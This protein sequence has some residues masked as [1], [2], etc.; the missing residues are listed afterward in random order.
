MKLIYA[1]IYARFKY[2]SPAL[3]THSQQ[4]RNWTV[5][6][7]SNSNIHLIQY[8]LLSHWANARWEA[9]AWRSFKEIIVVRFTYA[10]I[11]MTDCQSNLY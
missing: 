7:V 4:T 6:G 11:P 1:Y 5:E 3:R 9:I 8:R 10:Q 2:A